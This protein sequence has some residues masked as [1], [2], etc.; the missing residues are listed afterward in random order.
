MSGEKEAGNC[1]LS[2]R[3]PLR[4]TGAQFHWGILEDSEEYSSELFPPRGEE[5]GVFHTKS[6]SII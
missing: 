2:S 3:L 4:A 1:V 6:P 5:A